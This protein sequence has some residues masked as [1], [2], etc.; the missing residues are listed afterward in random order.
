MARQ[1]EIAKLD[2]VVLSN[3]HVGTLEIPVQHVLHI[4]QVHHTLHDV[5]ND[6]QLLLL[7]ELGFLYVQLVVE[8]AILHELCHQLVSVD[9]DA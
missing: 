2:L 1:P 7:R 3:Q 5:V 8:T 6:L 9:R 4:V